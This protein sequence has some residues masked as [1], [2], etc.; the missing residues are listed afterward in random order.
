[1]DERQDHYT[2]GRD[3]ERD[4]HKD[5]R[6]NDL[7]TEKKTGTK[8]LAWKNIIIS[9]AGNSSLDFDLKTEQGS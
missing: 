3:I 7:M 1:M 4:T 6:P 2:Q 5:E 9:Q 8:F